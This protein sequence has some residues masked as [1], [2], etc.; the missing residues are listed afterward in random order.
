MRRE[1]RRIGGFERLF[2]GT[3]SRKLL[4]DS[5][6]DRNV[7][8]F[9]MHTGPPAHTAAGEREALFIC[10]PSFNRLPAISDWCSPI[11]FSLWRERGESRDVGKESMGK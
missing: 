1:E 4:A 8:L 6:V 2:V 7:S 9:A 3:K 11:D 10:F 5:A